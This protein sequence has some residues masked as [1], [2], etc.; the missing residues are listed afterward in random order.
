M[1]RRID[2]GHRPA[3]GWGRNPDAPSFRAGRVELLLPQGRPAIMTGGV[4]PDGEP[5]VRL[6]V[7]GQEWSAVIDTGFNGDL[8]LPESLR[9]LVHPRSA[10]TVE[11]ILAGGQTL[12]EEA[13]EV[14]FPF[15]GQIVVADATFVP[16]SVILLGTHL[17]RKHRLSI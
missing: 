1:V 12:F 11:S 10:G 5:L 14:E 16:D 8:E 4:N 15:D 9:L 6:V 3:T 7:G 17:L 2:R 13:F